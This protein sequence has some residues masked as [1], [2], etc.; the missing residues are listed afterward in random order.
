MSRTISAN[1][2]ANKVR[3]PSDILPISGIVGYKRYTERIQHCGAIPARP[4]LMSSKKR[5]KIVVEPEQ[6]RPQRIPLRVEELRLA[7][8]AEHAPVYP[9]GARK[10]YT[11]GSIHRYLWQQGWLPN[12]YHN[13]NTIFAEGFSTRNVL[14]QVPFRYQKMEPEERLQL[15]CKG[16]RPRGHILLDGIEIA[17]D[18]WGLFAP[19]TH[20]LE[21]TAL[22]GREHSLTIILEPPNFQ[23]PQHGRTSKVQ[24]PLSR[25]DLGWDFAP[26]LPYRGV[27]QIYLY[28]TGP[29]RIE[30][31]QLHTTLAAG[32]GSAELRLSIEVSSA[33]ARQA[34]VV[35]TIRDQETGDLAATSQSIH[36]LLPGQTT[37]GL[38]LTLMNPRLWWSNGLG[39]QPLYEAE[40]Q[41]VDPTSRRL[42]DRNSF[43]FGIRQISFAKGDR[44]G[45]GIPK[46]LL[47]GVPV[48]LK[49]GSLVPTNLLY[50]RDEAMLRHQLYL[51][52]AA[53][54]NLIRLS[55]SGPMPG[56]RE[57][58][59]NL[60]QELGLLLWDEAPLTGSGGD[61]IPAADE[62]YLE[63]M[64]QTTAAMVKQVRN[65]A[66]VVIFSGG[67]ELCDA[68]HAPL[69]ETTAPVLARIKEVVK[70]L[71]PD[72]YWT[73]T[74]P[75][76]ADDVHG[77]WRY[78]GPTA[79]Y[80][81]YN[82]EKAQ[83]SL[84]SEAGVPGFSS[85]ASIRRRFQARM[86]EPFDRNH[87]ALVDISDFKWWIDLS[88]L[89]Q[90]F[91]PLKNLASIIQASQFIQWD[92][93][94]YLLESMRHAEH[95]KN[96]V[97]LWNFNEP[98]PNLC[99]TNVIDFFGETKPAYLALKHAFEPLHIAAEVPTI[100]WGDK[101]HFTAT[102]FAS[103]SLPFAA[104]VKISHRLVGASNQ[105]YHQGQA[106]ASVNATS[107]A[108]VGD[109]SVPLSSLREDLF[110]LDLVMENLRAN[111]VSQNRYVFSRTA[112][113]QPL[114]AAPQT[115]L[116]VTRQEK[117]TDTRVVAVTNA[118]DQAAMFVWLQ[119]ENSEKDAGSELLE[120]TP[121]TIHFDDNYFCL[122]PGETRQVLVS[123]QN[124]R[125]PRITARGWNT[126]VSGA[127]L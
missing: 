103:N 120:R 66:A 97:L 61:S 21:E 127:V 6:P 118:G 58:L 45:K 25:L 95:E 44:Y 93:I 50:E 2:R 49:G 72:L 73:P 23:E 48:F 113:L 43:I 85:L 16:L 89:Q 4:I 111:I 39:A 69:D 32:L 7:L 11:R 90:W 3:E 57:T 8:G 117:R 51:L 55:G 121:P 15:C 46:L 92:G 56:Q 1:L 34:M 112:N 70:K 24:G 40:V 114:S 19:F 106:H 54:V 80:E 109:L 105:V 86:P 126:D 83:R 91:G 42:S 38:T 33:Q 31:V 119:A 36:E 14:L 71:A 60:C 53:N 10:G 123:D 35:M 13:T 9:A 77:P 79:H 67:N 26:R 37:L 98:Y 12:P 76:G 88:H 22:D 107:G 20:E 116:Q 110:F 101:S 27:E 96:G 74:S 108:R 104:D 64:E 124:K 84:I 62:A 41:L 28:K 75:S 17:H 81:H 115:L 5:I 125:A 47:N 99:N 30:S 68:C 18:H 78:A 65:N 122:L 29:V 94:R 82:K 59:L 52:Q 102:L 63:K 87:P 100:T